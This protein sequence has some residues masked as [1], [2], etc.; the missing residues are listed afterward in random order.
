MKVPSLDAEFAFIYRV[1]LERLSR[2]QFAIDH[3]KQNATACATVGTDRG[4][5]SAV[6]RILHNLTIILKRRAAI[7]ND[8]LRVLCLVP[9]RSL[10]LT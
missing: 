4:N 2:N 1:S 10:T 9:P 6:H 7:I 8:T 5:E 3:L